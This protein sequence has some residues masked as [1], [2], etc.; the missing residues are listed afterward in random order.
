MVRAQAT[1]QAKGKA[2]AGVVAVCLCLFVHP[3]K[4]GMAT[5]REKQAGKIQPVARYY[6][7]L[8]DIFAAARLLPQRKPAEY[9][10]TRIGCNKCVCLW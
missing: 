3:W 8:I 10:F 9:A 7:G 1:A 2:A 4:D 6:Y 5:K